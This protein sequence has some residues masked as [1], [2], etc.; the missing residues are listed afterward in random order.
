[1]PPAVKRL[2]LLLGVVLVVA[3][4]SASAAYAVDF[5]SEASHKTVSATSTGNHVAVVAGAQMT[6]KKAH[7]HETIEPGIIWDTVTSTVK[8]T[9]CTFLFFS[10]SVNPN[11]CAFTLH[12][13]GEVDIVG[14]SCTG[15]SFEGAGCKVVIP[16]QTGL[17][18]VSYT[19]TGS[20]SGRK[21]DL[22]FQIKGMKY[23]A[24][25]LC[26]VTGTKTNG[27]YSGPMLMEAASNGIWV[28]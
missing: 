7:F 5:H 15:I 3:G 24:S 8:H 23:T 14:A 21:V 11:G 26:P 22:N 4:L 20:G 27:E 2:S 16:A 19:N 9:E 12:D 1:M 17:S 10:V 6:C 13:N 28:E 18:S 25:G